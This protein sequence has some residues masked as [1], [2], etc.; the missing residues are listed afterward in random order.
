MLI[1]YRLSALVLIW[2]IWVMCLILFW[3]SD[4]CI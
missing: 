1:G 3:R 2:L 4:R